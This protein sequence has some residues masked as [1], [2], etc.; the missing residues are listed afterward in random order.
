MASKP[1]KTSNGATVGFEE[2]LWA[3]ADKMRGHMDPAEYKHV[4]LGLIFL[5]YISDAF[6]ERHGALVA[7]AES[8]PAIDPEDR[9]EY[10]ADNIFWV[11]R[12]ARWRYLQANAKQAEIGKLIDAA[13]VAIERENP[14]LKG[15]LAKDYARP[16]IDK[17]Q[18][19]ELIDLISTIAMGDA[20]SR[21]KDLLGRVYEYFLGRFASAEGKGGGEFYTARCVVKLLVGL[22]V[23]MTRRAQPRC[24]PASLESGLDEPHAGAGASQRLART[25]AMLE[26]IDEGFVALDW[27]YRYVHVNEAMLRITQK[28]RD[29]L[30][31]HTSWELFPQLA[32]SPLEENYR[33]AMELGRPSVF[34]HRA[35]VSGN[36]LEVRIYPT[37]VGVS[38]YY[39]EI[40]E[41]KRIEQEVV[42][43]RAELAVTLAAITDGFYT[44]DRTWHV[45]YLN[46]KAVAVFP[47]GKEALGADFWELFPG[48]V[49]SAYEVSKRKAMEQGEV[50]SFEFFDPAS[51]AWFEERDYP[52]AGGITVLF[53][54]ITERKRAEAERDMLMEARNLLLEAATTAAAGTD[55]DRMLEA[56][57]DLLLRATDHSRILLELWDEERREVEIAVSR[58]AAATPKQRFAFDGISDGAKEVVTTRKTLVI[59]YAATGIPGPQ[60]A[61]VDEHAFLLMLVVPI[62]YRERLI[63]LITL[64]QPGEAR[65]FSPKEIEL[66]EAIAAQAGAAIENAG[67][68]AESLE[69]ERLSAAL[70]EITA[71]IA[72]SLDHDEI[73]TRVVGLTGAALRAESA[74][75]CALSDNELVPSHLWQLS[76]EFVGVPIPRDKVPYVNIGVA[77]REVVA[78]D[79]CE[80]DPRVDLELQ[81]EWKVRSVVM[82]PLLARNEVVGAMFF[83]YHSQTHRFTVLEIDFVEKAAAVVSGALE[84]AHLHEDLRRRTRVLDGVKTI[85]AAALTSPR[86]EDLGRT[87]LSVAEEVTDS[88]FG[89]IGELGSDGLLRDIAISDAGREACAMKDPSGERRPPEGFKLHGLYGEVL[90]DGQSLYTNA[91]SQHPASIGTPAG[92]PPLTALLGAPL[93]LGARTIGLIAV[94][95][96]EDGYRDEQREALEELAAAVV[97]AFERTR[98]DEA[99]RQSREREGFLADVVENA[100]IAFGVGAPDGR[101]V[102]F[103]QAFA[104]LTSYS[105][106]ELAERALTWSSDLTPPEW[107]Q[108]ETR[109]L[110]E[111]VERRK[112]VRYE[113]EYL[114]KDGSRVPIELFVQPVFDQD[115]TLLHYRSFLSDISERKRAEAALRESQ[116]QLREAAAQRQLALDAAKLGWWHYDPL[117]NVSWYD[118]GYCT[119]FDVTGSERPNDEILERLHP[120]DLPGV[121]AKVEAALDPADPKPYAA[122][123]RIHRS[124]GSLRWVEAHGIAAFEGEGDQR[125]ATSL[126][127]TVQDITE[128]KRGEEDRQLLL[129]ESQAQTE[130]LQTQG[131]ELQVQAEELQVQTEELRLRSDDLA[132]RARLAIALNAVN[133]LVHSTLEFEEIM[134]RALNRGV[135]ALAVDAGTIEMR[136]RSQWVVRYQH[137]FT[138]TDIG[139]RLTEVEAPNATR[140]F[141]SMKPFA[142]ADMRLDPVVNVGFV[143][144]HALRSLLAVPLIARD[145][146]IGCLLFYGRQART[147]DEAEMDFAGKLGATVSLALENAR[148]RDE[149]GRIAAL[150]YARSLIEASLDPLVTISAEGKI[151]DVN[152][153]TEQ[154][155][156]LTREELIGTRFSDYFTEPERARAGYREVFATGSVRDYPLAIRHASGKIT[157]VLY[158]A[159]LY[160]NEAGE[161][162]GIFAAARD[163]TERNRAQAAALENARLYEAQREI[164]LTLQENFVHPLPA[165]AGLELAELSLPAGRGDLVGGDFRDVIVRPDGIVVALIGDVTGKGIEAAGFTETVRAAART[166]ALISPAPEYVLGNVNRLILAEGEHQQLAT[167]LVVVIDPAS[168]RGLLASAGHPPA[169]H[170]ADHSC[171]FIQPR[172]GLPLG[173]LEQGYEPTDF[174]LARGEALVLYTDGLT[175]ARHNGELFGE[176]RLL[177]VLGNAKDR[178]PG[179]LAEALQRA[180]LDHAGELRDDLQIL[181]IRRK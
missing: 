41:R 8:E 117:T 178:H 137:G 83:N 143:R 61:Y 51:D 62:V 86:E 87:C 12:E 95:N 164:A 111:A 177:E 4:A 14:S 59:D 44:L 9:D 46:D 27:E 158:N 79:D 114:R 58:G 123:Y 97:Q 169:V 149:L 45:T 18:L 22:E 49:G 71:S 141:V 30:L 78:I 144:D 157:E 54:D 81:H 88:T 31:G 36:W 173:V 142:I 33:Q 181:A 136:D 151:T 38:A 168:G 92:H 175:E 68:L 50:C 101:L 112:A 72:T 32:G 176:K 150:R 85:L 77:G 80:T 40:T 130:E 94:G 15:V 147:F 110:A 163:V 134:Q 47:G 43:T 152:A 121:W 23:R 11:P 5:K 24:E 48:D 148:Q 20:E 21:S 76:V 113:K 119:I 127:G 124:D 145:A 165:I 139:R 126:V 60:K 138:E 135:E 166:L 106:A 109:L 2:K 73:L 91:P 167:A 179:Q 93:K 16:A 65:P 98:A 66:V 39:R 133:R 104:D 102:L 161:V 159:S 75:I 67:L 128:R 13:M 55:L 52:S 125:H 6:G 64:D 103:N 122:E 156:G 29:E 37:S 10:L 74:A 70:N 160:R 129:E 153:A 34:E 116:V 131:E 26:E 96:R 84:N 100:D 53:T 132:E 99:L 63:G 3:A 42:A 1:A 69:R 171:R 82:A 35:V 146:V 172:F 90:T 162:L 19:G 170:L 155:T 89:F 180:V 154:A 140:A 108:T 25:R 57:G 174:T 56:L 28:S 7:Q 115:G 105:R 120:D 107:R 118:N 17:Q